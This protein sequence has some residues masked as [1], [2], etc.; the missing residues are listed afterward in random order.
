MS[1]KNYPGNESFK[2]SAIAETSDVWKR[3]VGL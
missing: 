3:P 1:N 2:Q